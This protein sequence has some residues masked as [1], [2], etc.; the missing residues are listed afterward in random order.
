MPEPSSIQD[1]S[2]QFQSGGALR[3]S[4]LY[5]ER[6]ADKTLISTLLKSQYCSVL[7]PRQ[8]GKS[9]LRVHVARL[10]EQ[11]G[12]RCVNIDFTGLGIGP[13][14]HAENWYYSL[15]SE[16]AIQLDLPSV[17]EFWE[18]HQND[19]VERRWHLF[20]HELVLRN[21]TGPIVIFL[22]EIES[23]LSIKV[24]RSSFFASL[25]AF[26]NERA[27]NKDC[28]LLT[29]CLIGVAA[30]FELIA[31]PDARLT[32]YNV[33]E[34]IPLEDFTEKEVRTFKSG[35]HPLLKQTQQ[36]IN[37]IFA[38]TD[39]HPYMTHRLCEAISER[40]QAGVDSN[41]PPKLSPD[42]F[43]DVVADLVAEI[44]TEAGRIQEVSIGYAERRFTTDDKY[45]LEDASDET[46][47]P[48]TE[49]YKWSTVSVDDKLRLYG[50]LLRKETILFDRK[51]P[52]H[53]A[54][55]LSGI[56]KAKAVSENGPARL[57]IRNR[58]FATVFGRDW[59]YD[60]EYYRQMP[61]KLK[62]WTR[63]NR[64]PRLLLTDEDLRSYGDLS[65]R[66]QTSPDELEFINAS[67]DARY[68]RRRSLVFILVGMVLFMA[69]V[70]VSAVWT[71]LERY[72]LQQTIELNTRD[73]TIQVENLNAKVKKIETDR[74][75]LV[76]KQLQDLES[77]EKLK[78]AELNKRDLT[79][80]DLLQHQAQL[81]LD[82][83]ERDACRTQLESMN[84]ASQNY[85]SCLTRIAELDRKLKA[86]S[87]PNAG[88]RSLAL[89]LLDT[90]TE[91][92]RR[93]GVMRLD[94][95]LGQMQ[96]K[97]DACL[98]QPGSQ[99]EVDD[100]TIKYLRDNR[101]LLLGRDCSSLGLIG[102]APV[103]TVSFPASSAELGPEELRVLAEG[104]GGPSAKGMKL[105]LEGFAA[106]S[107]KTGARRL[108]WERI[109]NT[110]TM[111]M[112][113]GVP[114]TGIAGEALGTD[115][116]FPG[117]SD[118]GRVEIYLEPRSD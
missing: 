117:R 45:L 102:K 97:R 103:S 93:T 49:S 92:A 8:I 33:G 83:K 89:P 28:A 68:R 37:E 69:G 50:G 18:K 16:I 67:L 107:E 65:R 88:A 115:C 112:K 41:V 114:S 116:N 87:T 46:D 94:A 23:L 27:D 51:H 31:D 13:D 38:W 62:E 9:S 6:A 10:L 11:Q 79:I 109:Y 118:Q 96:R 15:L 61:K 39:G 70:I 99:C 26:Y 4:A 22:D 53:L 98:A 58:I 1:P 76:A 101:R 30:P 42:R 47:N 110:A 66:R 80:K 74:T 75:N 17:D 14:V 7:A 60:Q 106:S 95:F 52:V 24:D 25:R 84:L 56:V 12:V 29:F 32:P 82:V 91:S 63:S 100:A 48:N 72:H 71:I 5:V 3:D 35:F 40:Y 104:P 86:L 21:K 85:S 19:T 54:M 36:L 77:A 55:I 73:L 90:F 111:L 20:L 113:Y 81:E 43:K 108:S 78:Q 59:L 34:I 44:F 105:R 2:P 57:Q 64:N